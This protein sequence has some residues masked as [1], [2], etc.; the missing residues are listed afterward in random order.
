MPSAAL[1]T[2][3]QRCRELQPLATATLCS[4][5]QQLRGGLAQ[6]AA[7]G[8][9]AVS[10]AGLLSLA[11]K[12]LRGLRAT[13][14]DANRLPEQQGISSA[15][16]VELLSGFVAAARMAP[17]GSPHDKA[18]VAVASA[19]LD[20]TADLCSKYLGGAEAAQQMLEV[21]L[22]QL[23][24]GWGG[25]TASGRRA[26]SWRMRW[27]GTVAFDNGWHVVLVGRMA[28]ATRAAKADVSPNTHPPAGDMRPGAAALG[29]A[30][31]R[32]GGR[33]PAAHRLCAPAGPILLHPA[34]VGAAREAQLPVGAASGGGTV[35]ALQRQPWCT[36]AT[37]CAPC[38]STASQQ[39]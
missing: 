5:L 4:L 20:C 25:G 1:P 10:T 38:L 16:L 21:L 7:G 9:A 2:I 36:R 24:V 35:H 30:G 39:R 31:R 22:P 3:Q 34:K 33:G 27:C 13:L 26:W 8:A 32:R 6:A 19:A 23:Q 17:P 12:A 14:A 18:A 28:E 15:A 11:G 37:K 29:A